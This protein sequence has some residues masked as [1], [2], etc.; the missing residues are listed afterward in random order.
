MKLYTPELLILA[1]PLAGSVLIEY[2]AE[3]ASSTSLVLALPVTAEPSSVADKL[4]TDNTGASFVPV[5][6]TVTV[7]VSV[8]PLPSLAVISNVTVVV[9]FTSKA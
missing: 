9:S 4:A 7:S 1:V 8:P 6:V 5:I 2:V 3:D